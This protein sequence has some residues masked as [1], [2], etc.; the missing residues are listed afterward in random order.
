[1]HQALPQAPLAAS[2]IPSLHG[3]R[4][5]MELHIRRHWTKESVR[6]INT[7]VLE[8]SIREFRQ[9]ANLLE[10]DEGPM[11]A[12]YAAA[13]RHGIAV[14]EAELRRREAEIG[15]ISEDAISSLLSDV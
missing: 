2:V 13:F 9:A 8:R 4:N 10:D 14:M 3:L 6:P 15:L 7:S 12:R 11:Q 5:V 1:M